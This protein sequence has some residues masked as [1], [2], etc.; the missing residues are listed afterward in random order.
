MR[1]IRNTGSLAVAA[2]AVLA[3]WTSEAAAR[4]N[5]QKGTGTTTSPYGAQVAALRQTRA[6]LEQADHD[7]KGHR[8][9]AVKQ[10]TAAIHALQPPRTTVT[11]PKGGLAKRGTP[12]PKPPDAKTGGKTGGNEP[13][14]VSDAQLQQAIAQLTTI[15]TQLAPMTGTG[16]AAASAAVQNAV[17]ELKTA[18][19]IK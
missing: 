19:T 18:L 14:A 3:A 16:P 10:I 2:A 11:A 5:G 12:G 17:Q 8:A 6:L 9:A 13:Q 15:Q 7:Y 4:P 1:R